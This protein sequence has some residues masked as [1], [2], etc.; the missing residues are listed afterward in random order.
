MV[1]SNRGR[2]HR[3]LAGFV[4]WIKPDPKMRDSI[5]EQG[6]NIREAIKNQ[7]RADGLVVVATPNGGSFAKRTGLRRHMRGNSEIEG[8]D[9]DLPFVVKPSTK[10]GERIG[11]LLRRF[12]RY[13][14]ASYP[15]TPRGTTAS[16][17][18]MRFVASK[19]NYDLVPMVAA[20]Y[21]DYQVILKKG[22][23]HRVTSVEKHIDF[24]HKRISSSKALPGRVRFNDC[25][26]LMKWWRYIR[27][28]TGGSIEEVRTTLVELLCANAYDKLSV[29]PTYT[30]TLARWFGWLANVTTQR[31]RVE[32]GDYRSI[33]ALNKSEQGNALWQVIDP[34][35][36]N[37]NVVHAEWGNIELSEFAAWF[38]EGGTIWVDLWRK[39]RRAKT[40]TSTISSVICSEIQFSLMES[41]RE[42][43]RNGCTHRYFF[44]GPGVGRDAGGGGG[45]LL[46]RLSG[47]HIL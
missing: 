29:A 8:Q 38:A 1:I 32:F 4:D 44:R 6:N 2:S 11:E 36:V 39:S 21:P 18:E 13:A 20:Q 19:L 24:V 30:E 3:R 16:S 26:R 28:S 46:P 9:V 40:E 31:I 25:V 37:N 43:Y 22:G 17:V 23:N 5:R 35:N 42:L 41:C 34:V 12:E 45:L 15:S 33:E 10:D 47:S 14:A 7:A 27:I